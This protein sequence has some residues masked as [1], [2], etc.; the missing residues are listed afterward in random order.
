MLKEEQ[1]KINME[2]VVQFEFEDLPK[3]EE[4]MKH[5]REKLEKA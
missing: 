3:Q 1:V 4:R 2:K 5:K